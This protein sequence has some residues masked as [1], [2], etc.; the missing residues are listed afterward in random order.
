MP[1]MSLSKTV[2]KLFENNN[3][4]P[5]R[6]YS[7]IKNKQVDNF[8]VGSLKDNGKVYTEGKDKARILKTRVTYH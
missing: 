3:F 5:K 1:I 7:H 4:N 8:C 2:K 6:L